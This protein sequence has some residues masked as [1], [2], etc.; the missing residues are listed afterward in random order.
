MIWNFLTDKLNYLNV[1]FFSVKPDV[2][3]SVYLTFDDGPNKN[4][5]KLFDFLNERNVSATHFWLFSN[6][7]SITIGDQK[8][9]VH[10]WNHIRYSK[11][12]KQ[13]IATEFQNIDNE[14]HKQNITVDNYFRSPYGSYK[15]GLK[16][17][18]KKY[19][20]RLIFWSHLFEDYLP[21]F[22][23]EKI[24]TEVSSIR[25]GSIIVLHDKEKYF[26]RIC[27]TVLL[28]Q[29]ELSKRNLHLTC[30]PS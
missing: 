25:S 3:N 14:I 21:D 12:S 2:K 18:C 11:L 6:F 9:A 29:S 4:T 19:N 10:G 28:L 17:I 7:H 13:E 15:L 8:I 26:E 22:K 20:L 30:L 24:K 27:E 23:P 1:P 5:Q 16:A